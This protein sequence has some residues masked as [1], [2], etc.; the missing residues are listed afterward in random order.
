MDNESDAKMPVEGEDRRPSRIRGRCRDEAK[1]LCRLDM[2]VS[3]IGFLVKGTGNSVFSF[4]NSHESEPDCRPLEHGD[5]RNRVPALAPGSLP[6]RGIVAP[7][8]R[9]V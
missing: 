7:V 6:G 9:R 1:G 8:L 2:L 3:E 4:R 5:H